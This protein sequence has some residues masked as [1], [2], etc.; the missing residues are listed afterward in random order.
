[1]TRFVRFKF[2]PVGGLSVGIVALALLALRPTGLSFLEVSLL[3]A[4]GG[5]GLGVMYPVTTVMVQNAVAPHQLGTAT[6]SLNFARQLGGAMIVAAFATILLGGLDA[7]GGGLTL[8]MLAHGGKRGAMTGAGAEA[9]GATPGGAD[10][11]LQ[12]RLLFAAGVTFLAAG[13]IAVLATEDR[14]LR[15]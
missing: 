5:T 7:S 12:F 9:L 13:L 4:L 1:M 15:G 8:E 10:F 2:I 3:L 6:G 11:A 14:P